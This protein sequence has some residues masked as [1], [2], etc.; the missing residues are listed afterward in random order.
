MKNH[1]KI[2]N[3]C[4]ENWENMQDSAEGKFCKKCS[5]CVVDFTDK[6]DKQVQ[7]IFKTANGKEICGRISARSLSIAAAGIILITNLTFVQAQT[8]NNSRLATEQKAINNTNISGKLIFKRTKKA[9]ANA[10]VFFIHKSKY[11]KTITDEEG[12]FS[13]EIPNDLL[14]RKNVLYFD[15]EKLN[16][17]TRKNPDRKSSNPM[18][19]DIY[20]NTSIIFTK[21]EKINK[22]VF[23][24]D[25]QL[26]YIGGVSFLSESPPDYYYFNG[27]SISERKFE[28]LKKENPNYQYFFF[29]N[30]EAEVIAQKSYLETVQLL[31]SN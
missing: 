7:D 31:F 2:Q 26:S 22:N 18:N 30:K 21:N 15:F 1:I 13:L 4:P 19:G 23:Q 17:E 29:T 27:K 14:E 12:N 24:I 11:F 28:K 9:I 6:T 25:S 20:E 10:E 3:P 8:N 16:N 5:K